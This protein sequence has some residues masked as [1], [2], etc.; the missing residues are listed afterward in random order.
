MESESNRRKRKRKLTSE[1]T[2]ENIPTDELTR[3]LCF[4]CRLA[5]ISLAIRCANILLKRN[6]LKKIFISLITLSFTHIGLLNISLPRI[7]TKLMYQAHLAWH[8]SNFKKAKTY[9]HTAVYLVLKTKKNRMVQYYEKAYLMGSKGRLEERDWDCKLTAIGNKT[10]TCVRALR[11]GYS[12]SVKK[13]SA[14]YV[15]ALVYGNEQDGGRALDLLVGFG[16]SILALDIVIAI[17]KHVKFLKRY[18]PIVKGYVIP[19]MLL[20]GIIDYDEFL[21]NGKSFESCEKGLLPCHDRHGTCKNTLGNRVTATTHPTR[22]VETTPLWQATLLVCRRSE[23]MQFEDEKM[24]A[25][26]EFVENSFSEIPSNDPETLHHLQCLVPD[27]CRD[28]HTEAGKKAGRGGV[29]LYYI[30]EKMNEKAFVYGAYGQELETAYRS[31]ESIFGALESLD[32]AIRKRKGYEQ[33]YEE[34]IS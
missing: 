10:S 23:I 11:D 1:K 33:G 8:G 28:A 19:F 7:L 3:A 22:V 5:R 31:E 24:D 32:S 20:N 17:T 29:H 4:H 16:F 21:N 27:D 6:E 15:N 25:I 9:T 30:E 2:S 34:I 14:L 13:V 18:Q 12:K 26:F